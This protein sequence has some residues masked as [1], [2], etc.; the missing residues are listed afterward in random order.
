MNYGALSANDGLVGIT[1]GGGATDPG[2]TDLSAVLSF[3]ATDTTYERF[4][5]ADPNDLSGL[6]LT[7]LP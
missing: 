2:E 1:Q 5:F 6:G 4:T 3:S 7:Y